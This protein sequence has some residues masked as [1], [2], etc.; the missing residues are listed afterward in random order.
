MVLF[1]LG[2]CFRGEIDV[3][4]PAAALGD[5]LAR[6]GLLGDAPVHSWRAPSGRTALSWAAHA[7]EQVGGVRYVHAEAT[8][9]ALFAGRP[10]RWRNGRP[11]GRGPLDPRTYLRPAAAWAGELD[12]RCTALR[13]DD[14]EGIVELF[15]DPLGAY[16]IFERRFEHSVWVSNSPLALARVGGASP[17][18]HL[19]LASVVGGGWSLE[20]HPAWSAVRRVGRGLIWSLGPGTRESHQ[21]LLPADR[22]ARLYGA[23]LD[24]Q[25]AARTLVGTL[26]ALSDWPGRPQQL[27]LTGGR[28]SRLILAA[29]GHLGRPLEAV[30]GG[31]ADH[32][33][34]VVAAE[35]ARRT[36]VEHR[37]LGPPPPHSTVHSDPHR[38][39]LVVAAQSGATA[40]LADG[41]GFPV[42]PT[43]GPLALWHTGQGGEIGRGY[44]GVLAAASLRRPGAV[45]DGLYRAF[46]SV[47]PWRAEA[48]NSHGRALVRDAI[49]SWVV[50]ARD[51]GI[52][53]PDLPD[54][55][56]L[57]GRM[58]SWAAPTHG[59]VEWVRDST[60]ALWSVRLL[61]DLIGLSSSERA[62]EGFHRRL[63][64][65][66]DADL[67]DVGF[68]DGRPWASSLS[69]ARVHTA[70]RRARQLDGEVRRRLGRLTSARLGSAAAVPRPGPAA[71]RS[72]ISEIQ[73]LVRGW[74]SDRPEHAAWEVLDRRRVTHLLSADVSTLDIV[75]GYQLW[76]LA[77][78]LGPGLDPPNDEVR[79]AVRTP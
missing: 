24:E 9:L 62:T 73:R 58:A 5:G 77:T 31:E 43:S 17:L 22:V 53:P 35:L 41:A 33:D 67:L 14:G 60:S 63:L 8:R 47:R 37:L 66:L 68:A 26:D 6:L 74:A 71:S 16:P 30:T 59:C 65:R 1:L 44:Y 76:R 61:P 78:V 50:G 45:V 15:S 27:P 64:A 2:H 42:V 13:C 48:L 23:G 32:P 25:R 10:V 51:A 54:A 12:G 70:L 52:R 40:T 79:A 11:D 72:P 57:L 46:T 3:P 36:G 19:V 38:G 21:E 69:R 4:A 75:S 49:A 7:P 28:D 18:D 39:A 56:Y 34:V 20:G 29:A 55:F